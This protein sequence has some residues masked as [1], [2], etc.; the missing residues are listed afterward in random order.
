MRAWLAV[1]VSIG[2]GCAA[3]DAQPT[4]TDSGDGGPAT[5]G[6]FT[7]EDG[8]CVHLPASPADGDPCDD[9]PLCVSP[10]FGTE[11]FTVALPGSTME[12]TSGSP[13]EWLFVV[14]VH[15]ANV[16]PEVLVST[17]VTLVSSGE[18][19]AVGGGVQAG[20]VSLTPVGTCEGQ[21]LDLAVPVG[22]VGG[23]EPTLDAVCG[24]DGGVGVL[25]IEADDL[26]DGRAAG[27]AVEVLLAV[28]PAVGCP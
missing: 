20:T 19:I 11:S 15:L 9:A 3:T 22:V 7:T 23:V 1:A 13:G 14:A 28:D 17:Q 27:A 10:G 16:H 21:A 2:S 8:L 4:T 12:V 25:Q 26:I 24:L 5:S 18:V 6:V